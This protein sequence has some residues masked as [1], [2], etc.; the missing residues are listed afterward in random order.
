MAQSNLKKRIRFSPSKHLLCDSQRVSDTIVTINQNSYSW[1]SYL[2]FMNRKKYNN[3]F[4]CWHLT[5]YYHKIL[6]V[7][8][9]LDCYIYHLIQVEF[10]FLFFYSIQVELSL[11]MYAAPSF[12]SYE[13]SLESTCSAVRI[14]YL[15][16]LLLYSLYIFLRYSQIF[17]NSFF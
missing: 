11:L 9:V 6:S 8:L 14:G 13:D 3:K 17:L 5:A 16:Y 7:A 15:F 2:P 12:C 4:I 10:I 1:F